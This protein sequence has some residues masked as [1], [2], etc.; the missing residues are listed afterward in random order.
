MFK[1]STTAVNDRDMC[2]DSCVVNDWL[3]HEDDEHSGT[4]EVSVSKSTRLT[5]AVAE[6]PVKQ[7]ILNTAPYCHT[8]PT[9]LDFTSL[10][11]D[12]VHQYASQ[13]CLLLH[14]L[15]KPVVYH[16]RSSLPKN[17]RSETWNNWWWGWKKLSVLIALVSSS[18]LCVIYILWSDSLW[19]DQINLCEFD[20]I[21]VNTV[22]L[23]LML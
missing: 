9:S 19:R 3:T 7:E 18:A 22:P 23:S 16:S 8:V 15:G 6:S 17:W 10:I 2:S 14:R 12:L 13:V 5:V 20:T 11:V 21:I 4:D 1:M